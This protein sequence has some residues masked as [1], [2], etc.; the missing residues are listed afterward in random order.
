MSVFDDRGRL[1]TSARDV[2]VSSLPLSVEQNIANLSEA[3]DEILV[4]EKII[5][6]KLN[7][8]HSDNPELTE[9]D[10]EPED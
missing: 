3:D 7:P 4:T 9:D 8:L 2:E 5:S 1:V 10:L 6:L